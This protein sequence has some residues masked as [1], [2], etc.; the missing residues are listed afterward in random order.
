[1]KKKN[2]AVLVKEVEQSG[3]YSTLKI[4]SLLLVSPL[5]LYCPSSFTPVNTAQILPEWRMIQGRRVWWN[6]T[7]EHA[8]ASPGKCHGREVWRCGL[9]HLAI[10]DSHLGCHRNLRPL[11]SPLKIPMSGKI[12]TVGKRKPGSL[13][14]SSS[15][16]TEMH[17]CCRKT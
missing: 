9:C 16:Y 14:N 3:C 10:Q 12:T 15:L 2:P 1:M 8:H 7:S 13:V 5:V 11:V 4:C 6:G 17:K